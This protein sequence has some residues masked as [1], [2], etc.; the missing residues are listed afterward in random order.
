MVN[1]KYL[2]KPCQMWSL[3]NFFIQIKSSIYVCIYFNTTKYKLQILQKCFHNWSKCCISHV[4]PGKNSFHPHKTIKNVYQDLTSR[5]ENNSADSYLDHSHNHLS[6]SGTTDSLRFR[7]PQILG[8]F[9]Q[10]DRIN[11][12]ENTILIPDPN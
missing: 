11:P 12:H 9:R 3:D 10:H 4:S 6:Q 7:S 2:F 8:H 1:N 5:I